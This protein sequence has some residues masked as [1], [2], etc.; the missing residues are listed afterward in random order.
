MITY[1]PVLRKLRHAY[2]SARDFNG[3]KTLDRALEIPITVTL[4]NREWQD[5][6]A[7]ADIA[8]DAARIVKGHN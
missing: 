4:L 2:K 6:V 5:I 3:D 1:A 7:A 8:D